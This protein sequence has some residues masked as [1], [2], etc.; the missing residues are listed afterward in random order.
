[1]EEKTL[2]LIVDDEDDIRENLRDFVEFKGFDVIEASN[3]R[4]AL[5]LLDR[6]WPQMILS[7][8]MMPD[9]T[10]LQLLQ[11]LLKRGSD[12]PIVIMT[13]FGTMEYAIEAMKNGAADFITKPIDLIYLMKVME[14]VLKRN[15]MEQKIK[16][17]QR[18]LEEDL[19][20]AAVI[21]RSML[22][23]P[24]ETPCFS[25][26]YRF[27]PLIAIGGDYLTLHQFHSRKFAIALYDVSGHG[28]SAALTAN[29]AHNHLLRLL[30]EDLPPAR[31]IDLL[32]RFV[33][34][35]MVKSSMFITMVVSVIDCER[36]ILT[37]CN[38][39]HPDVLV[40]KRKNEILESI[41]SHIPPIGLCENI[42]GDHNETAIE[43]ESGDRVMLYT[44]GVTEARNPQNVLLGR[45]GLKELAM[46]HFRLHPEAFLR[47]F[48]LDLN[49]YQA[50]EADD[51]MTFVVVDIK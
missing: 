38:A 7:D 37:I 47:Q 2:I 3:G 25:F 48:F 36:G 28:V 23:E 5:D 27:H 20:H 51:D 8:L 24:F 29:L 42:L 16:E 15:A 30:G 34:Q 10:G 43:I 31:T 26:H 6:H 49:E 11:E 46:K 35:K 33:D 22:P 18:Q 40:W 19:N 41:A 9:V 12:I 13:A 45:S 14:R 1:M 50:G 39:G 32:N 44:D 4:Q 17:Q 21:Q